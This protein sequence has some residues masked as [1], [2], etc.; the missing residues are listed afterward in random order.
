MVKVEKLLTAF[1]GIDTEPVPLVRDPP[2]LVIVPLEACVPVPAD[3]LS[4]P[5]PHP[6]NRVLTMRTAIAPK[7]SART[8]L[9]PIPVD[10]NN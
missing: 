7:K 6:V 4:V 2:A 8:E 3:V 1:A 5:L 10:A 9:F